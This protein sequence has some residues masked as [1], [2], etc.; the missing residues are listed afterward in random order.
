M[1]GGIGPYIINLQGIDSTAL[2]AG[3]FPIIVTDVNL[4]SDLVE[5]TIDEP[6]PINASFD[7]NQIPFVAT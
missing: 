5:I 7:P 6:S 3:N 2:P 1:S 4:C